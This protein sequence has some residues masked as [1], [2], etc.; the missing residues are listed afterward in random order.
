MSEKNISTG[1]R[2][3]EERERVG[4]TQ[5]ALGEIVK[6]SRRTIGNIERGEQFPS[7]EL[8]AKAAAIQ[9]D[10]QYILT[11]VRTQDLARIAERMVHQVVEAPPPTKPIEVAPDVLA[12]VIAGVEAYLDENELEMDPDDKAGLIVTLCRAFPPGQKHE[13]EKIKATTGEII[14]LKLGGRK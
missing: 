4:Y 3:A 8:L 11:G 7:G 6:L 13:R 5:S 12:G 1:R 9:M 10:I 2:F 14:Q